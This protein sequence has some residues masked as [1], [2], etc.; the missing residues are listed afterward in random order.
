[1]C[2][3][4]RNNYEIQAAQ[5]RGLFCQRDL[6]T[7]T[8]MHRLQTDASWLY[9]R[10]FGSD[11]RVG[12]ADGH[13]FRQQDGC[14]VCADGFNET[15]TIFDLLCDGKPDR[16][17]AGTWRTTADFGGHVHR[18][19]AFDD[20]ADPSSLEQKADRQPEQLARACC[21]LGGTPV[22]GADCAFVVPFFEDLCVM[23]QFWHGDE[24]FLP[25]LQF[26]WDANADQYLRYETMYYAMNLMR[27]R[28]LAGMQ[29]VNG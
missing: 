2:M 4:R 26:L 16:H 21:A 28:L 13:I 19:H 5:A 9:L 14:W 18:E 15:L 20:A 22:G 7:L 6:Q 12:R 29:P 3:E 10:L 8:Q 27:E 17:P 24:E 25:R 11:Y 1:M 23:V